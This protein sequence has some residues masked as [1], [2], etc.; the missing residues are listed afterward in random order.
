MYSRQSGTAERAV[1]AQPHDYTRKSDVKSEVHARHSSLRPPSL[2]SRS[3]PNHPA[4][5]SASVSQHSFGSVA[6]HR[7]AGIGVQP[8]LKVNEPG[9]RYEQEADRVADQVMRMPTRSLQRQEVSEEEDDF[10]QRKSTGQDRAGGRDAPGHVRETISGTGHP[11]DAATRAYMEPRFGRDFGD[12]RVHTGGSA[13]ASAGDINARAYTVGH[14]VVFGAGEYAPDS[15]AGR[16]LIAHELTHVVQQ[17]GGS[18]LRSAPQMRLNPAGPGVQRD[19]AEADL[20]KT[21]VETI[22]SDPSYF[23]N[24]IKN[25]EFYSAELAI[26]RY[27]DGSSIRLGLVPEYVESPFRGVDYRTARSLHI[28][29]SKTAPSIGTGSIDFLPRGA[30]AKFPAGTTAG[31][32]PKLVKKYGRTITFTHHKSGKIVPTEVNSI[33]APRLTSVLRDAEAEYVRQFDAMSKGMVKVLKKLEWIITLGSIFSGLFTGGSRAAAGRAAGRTGTR[34]AATVVGRAQSRLSQFFKGLLK[35]GATE[36]ITVEG[37]GFAGVRAAVNGSELVVTRSII[38][39]SSKIAGRGRL[40]H[41]AFERAAVQVAKEQGLK[42]A[43]VSLE[44]VQNPTWAAYLEAQGYAFEV[45]VHGSGAT[46]VLTKV[47]TF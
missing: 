32:I 7:R 35:S 5:S 11:L 36:K 4:G 31:D 17:R 30:N 38:V 12:V 26:L 8:K 33:S 42:T 19:I 39:N 13:A 21:P 44:L 29:V 45:L 20:A 18:P 23:E 25:I 3:S 40:V 37:V 9:D 47:F 10:L 41:G 22:M 15:S 43:R 46:R 24:G 16:R 14:D 28:T 2:A 27:K 6:V 34:A 1:P